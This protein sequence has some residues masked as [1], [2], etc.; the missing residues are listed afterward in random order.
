MPSYYLCHNCRVHVDSLAHQAL[1][2]LCPLPFVQ[3]MCPRSATENI[4]PGR[5]GPLHS[6]QCRLDGNSNS[7]FRC[8]RM[9]EKCVHLCIWEIDLEHRCPPSRPLF[10]GRRN[11]LRKIGCKSLCF[12]YLSLGIQTN[13]SARAGGSTALPRPKANSWL[14]AAEIVVADLRF[15]TEG[16]DHSAAEQGHMHKRL[17]TGFAYLRLSRIREVWRAHLR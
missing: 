15:I 8:Q 9:I 16:D 12:I 1:E 7:N 3:R 17:E 10:H 13:G 14:A 4:L 6:R 5:G 2:R 11:Q